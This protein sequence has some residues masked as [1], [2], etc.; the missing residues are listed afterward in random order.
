MRSSRAGRLSPH[1]SAKI[2]KHHAKP[3]G[4]TPSDFGLVTARTMLLRERFRTN[5][6]KGHPIARPSGHRTIAVL[7][8]YSQDGGLFTK[9]AEPALDL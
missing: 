3:A 2:A 8:G 4:L 9:K 6:G 5:N 7:R 1:A